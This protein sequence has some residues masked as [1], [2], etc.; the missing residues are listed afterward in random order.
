MSLLMK[1]LEKAAKD[2]EG[3]ETGRAVA[4]Q[5]GTRVAAS[6]AAAKSE[7][8]LEPLATQPATP[9]AAESRE[10]SPSPRRPAGAT[11]TAAAS[12]DSAQAANM[13]RA[14]RHEAG[15]GVAAYAREHPLV[16]FGTFATL[17]VIGYGTYVY[18]QIM[19][20]GLLS[21][22]PR[23]AQSPPRTPIAPAP[24]P[25]PAA[26]TASGGT[27][28][29]AQPPVPL[30]SLLP[31]LRESAEKEKPEPKTPAPPVPAAAAGA[32]SAPPASVA[33]AAPRAPRDTIKI[34]AGGATPTVS[35]LNAE[36]YAALAAGNFESS[37]RLYSQLLRS[38]PG[39]VDAVLGLA[40]IATQQGDSDAATRHYLKVLELDPRNALAQAGLIGIAGRAD[41]QG[42]ETRVKQL[43][44]RDPSAYLYFTLGN[45]YVDQNRWPDAQQAFFQ[46]YHLQPD[47]PD[48]AYNLAVALEQIGQPKPA[49][50]FYRRAAQLASAKGRVNFSIAAAQDRISKLEKVA[51]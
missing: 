24:I 49:L 35:P 30:T 8:M 6:A 47:N 34:T 25:P 42:A 37:Q 9:R 10:S 19:N 13:I 16:I 51:Q 12:S 36:A 40:A 38:E 5:S 26:S 32:A 7:L 3:S 46:A 21:A 41:P 29:A 28:A 27:I 14:G 43:I 1:A 22:P 31:Q 44:A 23:M 11:P 2:R 17:F 18:L 45:T 4:A 20:P 48:Y 50:D 39:N 33:A 15:G